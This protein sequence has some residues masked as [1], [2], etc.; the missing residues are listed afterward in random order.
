MSFTFAHPYLLLL[1]LLLPL[2]AWLKGR[3]GRPAAFVYSSTQLVAGV[4]GNSRARAGR[5]LAAL[6]WL[7]LA[8]FMVALAQ[9]RFTR[10]EAT[11]RASGVDIVVAMDLS[12]SMESE[13]FE[14][15]GQ[16]VNR[17]VM[18]KTVLKRFVEKR[19]NDRIGLVAFAGK[20]YI[21]CPLTLDH[22]FLEQNIERLKLHMV[23]E[24]TAIGSGLSAAVNR[25]RDLKAKSKIVILMT[26]GQNNA[27]KIP[28]LTAA[29]AAQALGVKVY[30][31]GI[32]TQGQAPMPV[33]VFGQKRYQM[34]P[35]DIDEE[36]LTKIA[37]QTNGKYYRADNAKRFEGI[38]DEIDELEKT[39]V[40]VKKFTQYTE[41]F[42]G[43]LA[44]GVGLLLTEVLLKHT[45]LRRLP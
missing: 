35:V 4:S 20:A 44:L 10:S 22:D 31:I 12:G 45:L 5:F 43:I 8:A 1:L 42:Q 40:D 2:L 33:Y 30:T 17:L 3:R 21:A 18:A 25:L 24:G 38:Y 27:G 41:L 19:P 6:R 36:T 29:E 14:L 28:P 15:Q 7:A 37:E 34:V 39:E 16:R 13:D 23:E 11:I 26:D 32:G 9:P